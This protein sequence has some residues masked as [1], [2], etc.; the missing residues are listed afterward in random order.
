MTLALNLHLSL[1]RLQRL[2]LLSLD[3]RRVSWLEPRL[4]EVVRNIARAERL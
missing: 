4:A 1:F 3:R 2:E